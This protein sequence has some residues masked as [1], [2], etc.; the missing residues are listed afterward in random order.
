MYL[1][2]QHDGEAVTDVGGW[3][4][5]PN[6]W[7]PRAVEAEADTTGWPV[8]ESKAGACPHQH[9]AAADEHAALHH[10][11]GWQPRPWFSL[12]S[13]SS[14]GGVCWAASAGLVVSSS[15]WKVSLAVWP[16]T[17]FSRSGSLSP[18]ASTTIR[19]RPWRMMVGSRVPSWS[20]RR[21]TTSM[22]CCTALAVIWRQVASG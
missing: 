10:A 9:V 5:A 17:C 12:G 7:V 21:F 13:S 1:A 8:W 3:W 2:V 14:S 22:D 18:G 19:S 11:H 20:M 15:S 6:R 4:L 16:I